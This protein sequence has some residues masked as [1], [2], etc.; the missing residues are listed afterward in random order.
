MKSKY[1]EGI[2]SSERCK[3]LLCKV[4]L[5]SAGMLIVDKRNVGDNIRFLVNRRLER[6]QRVSGNYRSFEMR[7][8]LLSQGAERCRCQPLGSTR[9]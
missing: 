4:I 5:R 9:K 2:A 7:S 1:G 8:C 3:M 6:M